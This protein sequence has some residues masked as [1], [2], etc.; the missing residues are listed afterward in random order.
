[1]HIECIAFLAVSFGFSCVI[2]TEIN[3]GYKVT[4]STHTGL[5]FR[6]SKTAPT[7]CAV[8]PSHVATLHL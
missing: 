7:N 5:I 2:L 3:T 4:I 1:M 6:L 8:V